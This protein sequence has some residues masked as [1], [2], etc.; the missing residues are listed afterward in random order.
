M[1]QPPKS[2][3]VGLFGNAKESDILCQF[4]DILK[5]F[6]SGVEVDGEATQATTGWL[7]VE[8]VAPEAKKAILHSKKNGEGV[9][10]CAILRVCVCACMCAR[11]LQRFFL[12]PSRPPSS[13][14]SAPCFRSLHA[15][16]W[17][18]TST[19]TPS[20][21]RLWLVLRLVFRDKP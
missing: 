8:V 18:A 12:S 21:K 3:K 15:A 13:P 4:T 1:H 5:A 10:V 2:P 9:F 19:L 16:C 11:S 6:P 14:L 7:E 20:S 17:Q